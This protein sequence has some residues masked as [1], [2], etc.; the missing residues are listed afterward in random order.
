[1]EERK[2]LNIELPQRGTAVISE[3]SQ[4]YYVDLRT[5][6]GEGIY[7]KDSFSL[8]SAIQDQINL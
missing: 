4:N 6:L 7:P 3:D 5:G 1:M 2:T 8:N